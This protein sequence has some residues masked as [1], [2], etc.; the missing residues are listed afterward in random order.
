MK[1]EKKVKVRVGS[2]VLW[3]DYEWIDREG[4]VTCITK[5][6]LEVID[7]S[8]DLFGDD[9][10]IEI[11]NNNYYASNIIKVIRY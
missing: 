3:R 8:D 7:S 11:G 6:N 5:F 1:K 10:F 9:I 4:Y 2:K